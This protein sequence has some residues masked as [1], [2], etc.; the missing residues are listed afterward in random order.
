M[1]GKLSKQIF[2]SIL[3]ISGLVLLACLVLGGGIF[4]Y[5]YNRRIQQELYKQALY[6]SY[7]I[8]GKSLGRF[9]SCLKTK[10]G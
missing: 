4:Y 6:L 8:N 5:G 10:T 1:K 2:T 3:K 9:K 7:T